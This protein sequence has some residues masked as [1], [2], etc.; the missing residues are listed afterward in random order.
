M[1][2]FITIALLVMSMASLAP[3]GQPNM[4]F[5]SVDDKRIGD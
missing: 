4:L 2:S 5:I 3:V 1:K